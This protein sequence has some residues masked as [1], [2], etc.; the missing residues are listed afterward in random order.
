MSRTILARDF[1]A[2]RAFLTRVLGVYHHHGDTSQSCLVADKSSQLEKSPVRVSCSLLA[3]GL[4]PCPN[5]LEIF[6]GDSGPGALR[7]LHDTL[8]D[9]VVDVPLKPRLLALEQPQL[10]PGCARA[11]AVPDTAA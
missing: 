4:N 8:G 9:G 6:Q 5:P 10:T 11:V 2:L 3:S 1:I 7:R